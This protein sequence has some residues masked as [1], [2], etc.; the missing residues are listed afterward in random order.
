MGTATIKNTTMTMVI[1]I[2]MTNMITSINTLMENVQDMTMT[3]NTSMKDINM[4]IAN[5]LTNI[6]R[7][8]AIQTRYHNKTN[9]TQPAR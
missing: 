2:T 3:T 8:A 1:L 6:A 5:T 7:T 9:R 4:I